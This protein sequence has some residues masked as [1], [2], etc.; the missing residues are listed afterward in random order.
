MDPRF[1]SAIDPISESEA[2]QDPE[3]DILHRLVLN[4]K[5]DFEAVIASG[6]ENFRRWCGVV[7]QGS[8]D[9]VSLMIIIELLLQRA[10]ERAI[11]YK[12]A[13]RGT[14]GRSKLAYL[15]RGSL[16]DV[17]GCFG[18]DGI[19]PMMYEYFLQLEAISK[20]ADVVEG[21]MSG[22][23]TSIENAFL[24]AKNPNSEV[25]PGQPAET[26][27][28]VRTKRWVRIMEVL[29]VPSSPRAFINNI[30]VSDLAKNILLRFRLGFCL[31]WFAT[32]SGKQEMLRQYGIYLRTKRFGF[33]GK[34]NSA[35]S[36]AVRYM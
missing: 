22:R 1:Y 18:K 29:R 27:I 10:R 25:A 28:D 2:K 30:L 26:V 6:N 17:R 15:V 33:T 14:L 13:R 35:Q 3:I 11:Q 23:I 9:C 19:I 16:A 21:L 34:K 36:V 20:R 4:A 31:Q 7:F 8:D 12:N 24:L 5:C 32:Y